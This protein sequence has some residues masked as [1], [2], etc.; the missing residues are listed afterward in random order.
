MQTNSKHILLTGATGY[1][2]GRLLRA[3]EVR[4]HR[5]RCL[6]RNPDF[7][8]SKVGR[9]TEVVQGDVGDPDSLPATLRGID[10]AYYLI[11]SMGTTGDYAAQD[12]QAAAAFAA[13]AAREGVRRIIYLGGLGEPPG[14]SKHLASRQEVGRILRESGV[15]T[16]E[17]RAS[18]VIG[19]GSLSFEMIRALV[20]KLPIMVTPRW[21]RVIAQPIAI[22]DVIDYLVA[23]LDLGDP[24]SAVFE[25]GGTDRV[26]YGD[27]MREYGAQRGLRRLMIPVPLLTP[28]LSSLWLGL[29]TPVYARVGRQLVDS[30]RNPTMVRDPSALETFA[31]RPRGLTDAIARALRNE[32][33]SIA[34]TRWSDALS[35]RGATP[36]WGGIRFGSRIVDSRSVTV[37]LSARDAFRAVRRI[38][39]AVG[40]YW[41]DW[42]WRL[43]GFLDLLVG[44]VGTRRGRRDPE[45]VVAGD[46]V[47]FWRVEAV[48][49]DRLLGLFAEMK[50][51]GRAWLQFEVQETPK[52]STIRQT[53]IF[54]P[55]GLLG[56][57]YWYALYPLHTLVFRGMLRGLARAAVREANP[58]G[59]GTKPA[60]R[61]GAP[62]SPINT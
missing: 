16:I 26:S 14:L 62:A 12:R 27:I 53:A 61:S 29:V 25:I 15:P 9:D 19:S 18:I 43:R 45:W 39:G 22:E 17:F 4:G 50:L 58:D 55:V 59:V 30:L 49:P 40:W 2:G 38:G 31:I 5:V 33:R 1:V 35:S 48:E 21:V 36:Q 24:G 60:F 44:G 8:R 34:E 46:T 20:E 56:L 3:L 41:G 32:D 54:D 10:T 51:P 23:S 57:L 28:K 6:S 13:A 47:D 11:H 37:P 52:G 7:L 42:L